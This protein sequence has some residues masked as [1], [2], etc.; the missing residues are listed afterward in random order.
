MELSGKKA[1]ITGASGGIGRALALVM[2]KKGVDLVLAAR[3]EKELAAA[4]AEVEATG[5]Q[6]VT[7]PCDVG[8]DA[9]VG[10]L[11]EKAFQAFGQIDILINNAG[12]AVRG[13]VECMTMPDWEFIVNTNL[14]GYVRNIQAFLPSMLA[15]GSG[16]I[17]NVS[18]IQAIACTGDPLNIPY[19][20]T[21]AGICGLSESLYGYL[22]PKGIHVTCAA[23]G[24]IATGMGAN[25]RLVGSEK[26][27]AEMRIKEEQFFKMPFFMKPDVM[28]EILVQAIIDEQYMVIIPDRL[29]DRLPPQG[30]DIAKLNEYLKATFGS[31]PVARP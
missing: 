25:C 5:R 24:A 9:D 28:A 2:A 1:V 6:A 13:Q 21:K 4:A 16:C 12:V 27:K 18:S 30:H 22:K 23:P 10:N 14:L 3:N 19:I 20:T 31:G 11:A 8:R 29:N 17:V 7:V 26:E 15:R